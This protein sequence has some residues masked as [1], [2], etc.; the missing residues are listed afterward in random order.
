MKKTVAMEYFFKKKMLMFVNNWMEYFCL[1][2][3][4]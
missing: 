1:Q 3:M 4:S 2:S